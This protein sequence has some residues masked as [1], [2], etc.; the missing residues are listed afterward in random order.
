MSRFQL[1][2][3]DTV[4]EDRQMAE[5][6]GLSHG[7]RIQV[8]YD[9]EPTNNQTPISNDIDP[10]CKHSKSTTMPLEP[11]LTCG[12]QYDGLDTSDG[13]RIFVHCLHLDDI[14]TIHKVSSDYP[15]KY[16]SCVYC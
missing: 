8:R 2:W 5:D 10:H 6:V 4:L 14:A 15:R 9:S 3:N 1:V 11:A 7:C 16:A 13:I 12:L